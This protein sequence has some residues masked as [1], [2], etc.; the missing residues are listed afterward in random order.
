MRRWRKNGT[1]RTTSRAGSVS[2]R[3]E[4]RQDRGL[5]DDGVN[6]RRASLL[7][8]TSLL[9]EEDGR[10]AGPAEKVSRSVS[11]RRPT[12]CDVVTIA[13]DVAVKSVD[14]CFVHGRQ[15]RIHART[16][17]RRCSTAM[18]APR[19]L[20]NGAD[21]ATAIRRRRSAIP[22][23]RTALLRLRRYAFSRYDSIR[24]FV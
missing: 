16:D 17:A 11:D 3:L 9:V 15:R 10:T 18:A 22:R 19:A 6:R 24:R 7:I 4:D 23:R 14:R 5:T 12:R 13:P 21:V 8:G 1:Y 20:H 2:V